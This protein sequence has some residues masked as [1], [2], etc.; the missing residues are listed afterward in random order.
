MLCDCDTTAISM[1][2]ATP[3]CIIETSDIWDCIVAKREGFLSKKLY[4]FIGFAR[5]QADK[6][7]IKEDRLNSLVSVIKKMEMLPPKDRIRDHIGSFPSMPYTS[8][9]EI[10]DESFY[11]VL[12]RKLQF[13]LTI[14]GALSVL[15]GIYDSYNTEG[16]GRKW[17]SISHA[18][19]TS[20]EVIELF[21][22]GCI[23]YPLKD[24]DLIR[25]IKLKKVSLD[26]CEKML[27]L[28]L[29]KAYKLMK[30]SDLPKKVNQDEFLI[31]LV[32]YELL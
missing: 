14:D 4:S 2:Y 1:L 23:S 30:E 25:D 7:I 17:K 26:D 15:Q 21:E 3:D 10:N 20:H 16:D 32:N 28:N 27:D 12:G 13:T 31:H 19:R 11:E 18:V 6:H 9:A 5:G 29:E 22:T 8:I 24:A